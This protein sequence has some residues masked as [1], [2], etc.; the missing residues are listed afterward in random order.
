MT[1]PF[2][3]NGDTT[4]AP[5]MTTQATDT[6]ISIETTD[7]EAMSI[8]TRQQCI[9]RLAKVVNVAY[10]RAHDVTVDEETSALR[11]P[12]FRELPAIRS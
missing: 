9:E 11:W 8:G 10:L 5:T 6:D 1:I 2:A 7:I 12:P 4:S 3:C